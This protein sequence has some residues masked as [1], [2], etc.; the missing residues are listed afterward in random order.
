MRTAKE[1]NCAGCEKHMATLR[2][3]KVRNGIVVYCE[4]CDKKMQHL[5]KLSVPAGKYMPD[6]MRGLFGG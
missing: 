5:L 2:D 4:R 1:L 3:A 6:F